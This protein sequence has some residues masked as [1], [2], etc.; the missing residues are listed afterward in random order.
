MVPYSW[1]RHPVCLTTHPVYHSPPHDTSPRLSS[2]TRVPLGLDLD[3]GLRYHFGSGLSHSVPEC[4]PDD[5]G[6]TG[7]FRL[8]TGNDA[9]L[10]TN[11][12]CRVGNIDIHLRGL[13]FRGALLI[14]REFDCPVR[15]E[16]EHLSPDPL[17]SGPVEA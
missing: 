15:D 5:Q 14:T 7:Q 8:E 10:T 2:G 16:L 4:G 3:R 12:A 13:A 1:R 17:V 6:L 11:A 9:L